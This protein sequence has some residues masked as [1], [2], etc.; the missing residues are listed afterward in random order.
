MLKYPKTKSINTPK[1]KFYTS[2]KVFD[3]LDFGYFCSHAAP[4][5]YRK[6]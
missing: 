2:K 3:L 4:Q 1:R 6:T 5:K